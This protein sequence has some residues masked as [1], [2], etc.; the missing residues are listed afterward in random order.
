MADREIRDRLHPI[1]VYVSASE[2]VKIEHRA[3]AV[4]LAPSTFM[5]S[6]ALGFEPKSAFDK[7][8]ITTLIKLH[9]DQGRLGGLLKLWLTEKKGDGTDASN[10]RSVLQ[11][12]E[13][14]QLELAHI[15]MTEKKR[16]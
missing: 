6:L 4:K 13:S 2:R 5:R 10:V 8:A 16:L 7:V 11:Q 14:L 12:I 9:A 3:S 1:K 15:V